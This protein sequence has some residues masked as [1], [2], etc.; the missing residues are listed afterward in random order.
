[1]AINN[2]KQKVQG[3]I[4]KILTEL[5]ISHIRIGD[6]YLEEA[7][8]IA[9]ENPDAA[10][11]CREKVY[12]VIAGRHNKSRSSVEV[13]LGYTIKQIREKTNVNSL[14][15]YFGK[16]IVSQ[17]ESLKAAEVIG[18]LAEYLRIQDAPQSLESRISRILIDLGL[19]P[20]TSRAKYL[21]KAIQI[22]YREPEKNYLLVEEILGRV[23][24]E[25]DATAIRINNGISKATKCIKEQSEIETLKKYFGKSIVSRKEAL[26][27]AEVVGTLAEYLRIQDNPQSLESKISRILIELGILFGTTGVIYLKDIIYIFYTRQRPDQMQIVPMYTEVAKKHDISKDTVERCIRTV[28]EQAWKTGNQETIVEYFGNVS[29][30]SKARPTNG[31]FITN[32]ANYLKIQDDEHN[33]IAYRI[34]KALNELGIDPQTLGYKYLKKAIELGYKES[35]AI[36]NYAVIQKAYRHNNIEKAILVNRAISRV[37]SHISADIF[38]KY[39]GETNI[40]PEKKPTSTDFILAIVYYLKAEDLEK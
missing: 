16:T 37:W 13:A 28:I 26:K 18:T 14:K 19:L 25:Y 31:Q 35:Q 27:P 4:Q 6:V 15:K 38:E 12:D 32:I 24:K 8:E 23:S 5:G 36:P 30:A 17:A 33:Q 39:F 11:K 7:I 34:T 20:N 9:Y 21:C 22:V 1:M 3:K 10:Y 40:E 2:R 29:S